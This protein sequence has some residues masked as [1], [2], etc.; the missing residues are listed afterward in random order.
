[1]GRGRGKG[2]ERT[3]KALTKIRERTPASWVEIHPDNDTAF[4]NWHLLRYAKKEE[5]GFSRSR[6]Y[7]KNDNSFVEQKNSTHIRSV[8]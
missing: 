2:Q 6:P 3:F 1:V 5:I 8:I 7:K 4:I